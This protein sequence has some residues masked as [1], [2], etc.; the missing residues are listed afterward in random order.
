MSEAINADNGL[1]DQ[2]RCHYQKMY[3]KIY[4]KCGC[5]LKYVDDIH[6]FFQ[7]V[8]NYRYNMEATLIAALPTNIFDEFGQKFGF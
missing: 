6:E 5:I 4:Q 8:E 1:Y 7:P 2:Q 3:T